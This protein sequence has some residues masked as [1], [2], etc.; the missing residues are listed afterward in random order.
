MKWKWNEVPERPLP[1]NWEFSY[2]GSWGP[3]EGLQQQEPKKNIKNKN[4]NKNHQTL[5]KK[6]RKEDKWNDREEAI[7]IAGA[8]RRLSE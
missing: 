1:V 7:E 6:T 4:K 3:I 5:R 2:Q 8:Y